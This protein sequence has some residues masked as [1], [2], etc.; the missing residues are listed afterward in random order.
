[1]S[2]TPGWEPGKWLCICQ[3]C[4]SKFLNDEVE[5]EWTGLLV[6]KKRCLDM[7]HPQDFV[8]SVPDDQSVPYTSPEPADVFVDVTY[9]AD[10]VGTQ[11]LVVP[12]GTFD[13]SL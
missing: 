13:G 1:M 5:K 10:T 2:N 4:G 11:D 6:C 7:R 12:S 3:R 8:R 9:I